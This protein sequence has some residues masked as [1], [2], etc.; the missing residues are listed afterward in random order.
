[1]RLVTMSGAPIL[2]QLHLEERLLRRTED[3]W[4]VINDGTMP[5]TIV[6]GVSG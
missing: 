5:P 6:M 3:N 1:M 4:C 2:R